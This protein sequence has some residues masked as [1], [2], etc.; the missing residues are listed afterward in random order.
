MEQYQVF[1]AAAKYTQDSI[2]SCQQLVQFLR[3]R[4]QIEEEYAKSLRKHSLEEFALFI[5]ILRGRQVVQVRLPDPLQSAFAKEL[6]VLMA[7]VGQFLSQEDL[8]HGFWAL[9]RLGHQIVPLSF[10]ISFW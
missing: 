8:R 5:F 2:E 9:F 3:R 7:Q 4:Q 6:L 10:Y 1:E